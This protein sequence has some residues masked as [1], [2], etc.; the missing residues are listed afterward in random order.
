MNL[1]EGYTVQHSHLPALFTSALV[2]ASSFLV[3]AG[4]DLIATSPTG[5]G[6]TAAYLLPI[7]DRLLRQSREGGPKTRAFPQVIILLPTRE[8]AA[9]VR[10]GG[11]GDMS[12]IPK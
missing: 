5:S 6:K 2:T 11:A 10:V 8:L 3:C 4:S 12:Q 1:D 7:V 9:Q